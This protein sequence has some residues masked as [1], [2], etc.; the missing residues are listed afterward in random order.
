VLLVAL[1]E[2]VGGVDVDVS[3]AWATLRAPASAA[4]HPERMMRSRLA[5]AEIGP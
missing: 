2:F 5:S 4:H 1:A 3:H